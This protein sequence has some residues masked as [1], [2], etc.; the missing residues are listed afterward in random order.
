MRLALAFDAL[1]RALTGSSELLEPTIFTKFD[2][3]ETVILTFLSPLLSQFEPQK[4]FPTV[5]PI[6]TSDVLTVCARFV[7]PLLAGT[8]R[9]DGEGFLLASDKSGS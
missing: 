8:I 6:E 9:K 7:F 5:L 4:V 1:P 3:V 2:D